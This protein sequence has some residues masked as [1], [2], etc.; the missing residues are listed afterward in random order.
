MHELTTHA[1]T[2]IKAGTFDAYRTA[3][4]TGST[5]WATSSSTS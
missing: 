2:A 5:P 4:L 1:R 3:I